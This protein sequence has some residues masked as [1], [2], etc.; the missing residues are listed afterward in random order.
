MRRM[1]ITNQRRRRKSA[2]SHFPIFHYYYFFFTKSKSEKNGNYI[3]IFNKFISHIYIK[4]K[5]K[6]RWKLTNIY[7]LIMIKSWRFMQRRSNIAD[8]LL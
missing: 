5:E 6:R 7:L 1:K 4:K 3:S 2:M 8:S